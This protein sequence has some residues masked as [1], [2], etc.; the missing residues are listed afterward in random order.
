MKSRQFGSRRP[1]AMLWLRSPSK[2]KRLIFAPRQRHPRRRQL[3]LNPLPGKKSG[4]SL[5]SEPHYKTTL[6][7]LQTSPAECPFLLLADLLEAKK[8]QNPQDT[9]RRSIPRLQS[10]PRNS[11][12]P[13]VQ[14]WSIE[15]TSFTSR[16]TRTGAPHAP[17]LLMIQTTTGGMRIRQPPA[18]L[19]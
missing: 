6:P 18:L 4:E 8:R 14:T 12:E 3:H 5:K 9:C 17:L 2:S 11:E 19:S 13:G 15:R 7:T 16:T 10:A 1:S